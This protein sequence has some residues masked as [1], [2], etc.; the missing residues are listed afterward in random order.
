MQFQAAAP[1]EFSA[2]R[3]FYW[4]L[5]DEMQSS[6]AQI[7]WKKGIYPSDALLRES[8]ARGELFT[9]RDGEVLCACVI[10]NSACN[11]GYQGIPWSRSCKP[12]E[13][14][15]PH[16][17]GVSPRRQ[18]AG[19]GAAVVQEILNYARVQGKRAVRLDLLVGNTAAER[20]YPKCGF[21]FVQS[22]TMFYEDTGWTEY[23]M[24]E[25][26]L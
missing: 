19:I 6:S 20:L 13:V 3:T 24:Y 23:Q 1:E 15:I 25:F 8:L 16:A 11:E 26:N 18:G 5:I 17:L 14:L 4:D 2:I 22:K 10:L 12:E 21:R 9:L 7:G